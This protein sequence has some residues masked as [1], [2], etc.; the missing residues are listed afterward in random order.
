M[1]MSV[2]LN[3]SG[4][5]RGYEK[6]PPGNLNICFVPEGIRVIVY[7]FPL[8]YLAYFVVAVPQARSFNS[9]HWYG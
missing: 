6:F 1:K 4:W 8:I 3:E 2:I 7:H 9:I 5:Q